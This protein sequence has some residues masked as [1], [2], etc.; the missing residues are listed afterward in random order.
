MPAPPHGSL[1]A[2]GAVSETGAAAAAGGREDEAV[3][4]GGAAVQDEAVVAGNSLEEAGAGASGARAGPL[5]DDAL[6]QDE[7]VVAGNSL[8]DAVG[9]APSAHAAALAGGPADAAPSHAYAGGADAACGARPGLAAAASPLCAEALQTH[10]LS[11]RCACC[12]AL[13]S[14]A[15][16]LYCSLVWK[17]ALRPLG[18]L[19]SACPSALANP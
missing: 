3:G 11:R 7:A 2:A 6:A 10:P 17:Q 12:C 15:E 14:C 16:A 1:P 9:P 4:D 19:T 13:P 18:A 5:V 8:Q